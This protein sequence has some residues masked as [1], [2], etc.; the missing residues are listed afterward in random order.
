MYKEKYGDSLSI[1]GMESRPFIAGT[2]ERKRG[3]IAE[4]RQ[5]IGSFISGTRKTISEIIG[6]YTYVKPI[7]GARVLLNVD[8]VQQD[9]IFWDM[10]RR[11]K[12]KGYELG[13]LF[14]MPIAQTIVS[15]V[16]G[17]GISA[18][19]VA[20]AAVE[21]GP[22]LL[23][24]KKPI[25]EMGMSPS[26]GVATGN[27]PYNAKDLGNQG[28]Q[29][30]TYNAPDVTPNNFGPGSKD[31]ISGAVPTPPQKPA[32][33]F[34][35]STGNLQVDYT[36]LIISR[37]MQRHQ[38][39]FTQLFI[40]LYGLGDQ[41][42][43]VNPDCSLSVASPET[44]TVEYA[45]G[46]YKTPLRYI[47]RTKLERAIV[48]DVYTKDKRF[49]KIHYYD[50]SQP[51]IDLVYDNLIGR[52]PVIHFTN[53]RSQN[54]IYG[55]PIYEPLLF[56]FSRYD[57]LLIK[58]LDGVELLAN[59]IPTFSE[60]D[61]IQETIAANT[62]QE[63]YTDGQGQQQTRN[64]LRFDRAPAL[65]LGK[66]GKFSFSG[67]TTG[68]TN[69]TSNTLVQL[70][71]LMMNYSRIPEFMWGGAISS[72]KASA[73]TQLPPFLKYV[74]SRRLQLEGIGADELLGE[75]S[76]GGLLELLDIYLKMY[77]LINP[78]IVIA[79]IQLQWP[80]LTAEDDQV[81]FQWVSW[82]DATG[83]LDPSTALG[84]SGLVDDPDSVVAKATGSN[85]VPNDYSQFNSQINQAMVKANQEAT[86]P[87]N[88]Q[89]TP[90][91]ILSSI[92]YDPN[93]LP[94]ELNNDFRI[95]GPA[96]WKPIP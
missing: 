34:N 70:F 10:L 15:Y 76:K 47:I 43:I 78:S 31:K 42:V 13:G 96:L 66:G 71:R 40:D 63:M 3:R 48:Q 89:S 36:N 82:A 69:D 59:P 46:D 7:W 18:K 57:D 74:Q 49:V 52:I 24:N 35:N 62:D 60:L 27:A 17:D 6:R 28:N 86:A 29:T 75:N 1:P 65:F 51:E 9:Y 41:Y 20:T 88:D 44:V 25:R 84:L 93:V 55:R 91:S 50:K 16:M 11:G 61:D 5:S 38:S 8:K 80:V 4:F 32:V 14:C 68:F 77:R 87:G 94:E 85:V 22:N 92:T 53:D 26:A 39:F 21:Q 67:P 83:K 30:G 23:N 58:Q 54:E 19:L 33:G 79:P 73:E 64:V 2:S 81:R 45:T 95:E 37:F 56:L 90:D 12:A 72:S